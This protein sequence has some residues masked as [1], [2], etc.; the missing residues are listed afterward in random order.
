MSISPKQVGQVLVSADLPAGGSPVLPAGAR[1]ELYRA[2]QVAQST[3]GQVITLDDPVDTGIVYSVDVQNTGS[4]SMIVYGVTIT[5][6]AFARFSW[7]GVGAWMPDVAPTGRTL[8]VVN[9][10]PSGQ[11]TFAAALSPTPSAGS[12]VQIHINGDWDYAGG[13][14]VDALGVITTLGAAGPL[15]YNVDVVDTLTFVYF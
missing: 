10:T 13:V 4:V 14:N 11:N 1:I 5:A 12:A 8:N 6:G 9:V 3:V 2:V 7:D 15:G